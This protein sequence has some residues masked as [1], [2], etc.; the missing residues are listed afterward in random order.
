M[1]PPWLDRCRREEAEAEDDGRGTA[2]ALPLFFLGTAFFRVA[3]FVLAAAFFLIAVSFL[4]AVFFLGATYTLYLPGGERVRR[5]VRLIRV[6][7]YGYMA[8]VHHVQRE[9]DETQDWDRRS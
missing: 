9:R 2:R 4:V 7:A 6:S 5:D 3:V 8:Y 1:T